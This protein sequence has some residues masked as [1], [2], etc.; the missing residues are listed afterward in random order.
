MTLFD[1][2]TAH[3]S[4]ST[5]SVATEDPTTEQ[6]HQPEQNQA[7]ASTDVNEHTVSSPS[8]CSTR[9]LAIQEPIA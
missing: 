1:E 6:Q 5:S 3:N 2:T 8:A 4:E 9:P 7:A